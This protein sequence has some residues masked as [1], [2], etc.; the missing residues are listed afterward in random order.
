[1]LH[2]YIMESC[3]LFTLHFIYALYAKTLPYFFH[4][5]LHSI[6]YSQVFL[7]QPGLKMGWMRPG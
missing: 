1:M 6:W 5:S 3:Y 2:I 7:I 4:S